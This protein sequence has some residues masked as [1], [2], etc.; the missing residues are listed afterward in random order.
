MILSDSDK[1]SSDV[2]ELD[3][4]D[5]H[6]EDKVSDNDKQEQEQSPEHS[7]HEE[8]DT[9]LK[10]EFENNIQ[11]RDM[12]V[13]RE[14]PVHE[15][16]LAEDYNTRSQLTNMNLMRQE[17][18]PRGGLAWRPIGDNVLCEIEDCSRPAYAICD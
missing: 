16:N 2:E 14:S 9:K 4:E 1:N 15:E 7:I 10:N 3:H 17:I 18:D 13:Y 6:E 12:D 8:S 11:L 5:D